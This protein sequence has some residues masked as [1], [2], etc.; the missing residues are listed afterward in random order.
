MHIID[1]FIANAQS[2]IRTA[3]WSSDVKLY[4]LTRGRVNLGNP[5][6]FCQQVTVVGQLPAAATRADELNGGAIFF[7]NLAFVRLPPPVEGLYVFETIA[8][9]FRSYRTSTLG[10]SILSTTPR[11]LLMFHE[12]VHL[13]SGRNSVESED[14][15]CKHNQPLHTR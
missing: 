9:A 3:Y 13:V 8:D 15:A 14:F 2:G 10:G 4:I 11:S 1:C 12:L 5:P 6:D 7:C